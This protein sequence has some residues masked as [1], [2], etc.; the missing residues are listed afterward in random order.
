LVGHITKKQ[1]EREDVAVETTLYQY[2]YKQVRELSTR[3]GIDKDRALAQWND[4]LHQLVI[5]S[6]SVNSGYTVWEKRRPLED[7]RF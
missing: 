7:I 1:Q 4:F 2:G 3:L 5:P 6:E